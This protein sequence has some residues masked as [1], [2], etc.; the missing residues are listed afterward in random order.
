MKKTKDVAV[1][2]WRKNL[3]RHVQQQLAFRFDFSKAELTAVL[4]GFYL[5]LVEGDFELIDQ[6][7]DFQEELR[8]AEEALRTAGRLAKDLFKQ[9]STHYRELQRTLKDKARELNRSFQEQIRANGRIRE[10]AV[11]TAIKDQQTIPT[12]LPALMPTSA[13]RASQYAIERLFHPFLHQLEQQVQD[14]DEA[15]TAA[16]QSY[17]EL[18][19]YVYALRKSPLAQYA[20][21]YGLSYMGRSVPGNNIRFLSDYQSHFNLCVS[22]RDRILLKL[23]QCIDPVID[24]LAKLPR[25][26]G[27]PTGCIGTFVWEQSLFSRWELLIFYEVLSY[28][29][30]FQPADFMQIRELIYYG[31]STEIKDDRAL[32]RYENRV[33]E[34]TL[35]QQLREL[36]LN[37]RL[38]HAARQRHSFILGKTGSG[39]TELLKLLI[40]NDI[41]AGRGVLL[42]DPHGDLAQQ[43]SR[44]R[45]WENPLYRDRLV[46]LSGDYIDEGVMPLLNPFTHGFHEADIH[47]KRQ[48]ISMRVGELLSAFEVIFRGEFTNN[49]SLMLDMCLRLLLAHEGTG[50]EDLLN[51]L[52]P[53]PNSRYLDQAHQHWDE[54]VRQYFGQ[55]FFEE[56]YN[57]T[58]A[59]ILTRFKTALGYE[60]LK[61]MLCRT[62][63]G[64][65]LS[66]LLESNKVVI[67]NASQ[68]TFGEAGS[69]ILGAFLMAEVSSLALSR[70]KLPEEQ[71]KEVFV[72]LDEC[73][74]FLNEKINKMLSETRKYKVYLTM[75][76]QHLGHF[77]NMP[78][79][80]HSIMSNTGV[81][82]CGSVSVEDGKVMS[83]ALGLNL[84]K[85]D[86]LEAGKFVLKAGAE[87]AL[88]IQAHS[89]LLSDNTDMY[90]FAPAYG[91][92]LGEQRRSYYL[93]ASE[94]VIDEQQS[95]AGLSSKRN[96]SSPSDSQDDEFTLEEI[97]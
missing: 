62:G 65:P 61:L 92:L 87:D 26:Y 71:R 41:I 18:S 54:D 38:P 14:S 6:V 31:S 63:K 82:I 40:Y 25:L 21:N 2:Q 9:R 45:L 24:R 7:R 5:E 94:S 43:C 32:Y 89:H 22:A 97:I 23:R 39:K 53:R 50:V 85:V 33:L 27:Q 84:A 66:A 20:E 70:S 58:K 10:K 80:R 75:A 13:V 72:Y 15:F 11:Q 90:L 42:V 28:F 8:Q 44:L 16:L 81:K 52:Y 76:T 30:A 48:A 29:P 83:K 69:R 1:E 91:Y 34:S 36:K 49:M 95:E 47:K 77:S 57:V 88:V 78:S 56:R 79:L 96:T 17:E 12:Y 46:Y 64:I 74:N 55:L 67:V 86:N 68:G 51:M 3:K 19:N 35:V 59:A 93:A 73:Q 4:D 37:Y 60:A